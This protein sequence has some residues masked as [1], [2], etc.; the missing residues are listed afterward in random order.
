MNATAC[1]QTLA[2]TAASCVYENCPA[3]Y[4]LSPVES[5]MYTGTFVFC[6]GQCSYTQM[7]VVSSIPV[8]P[9][10]ARV[11]VHGVPFTTTVWGN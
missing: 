9:V 10:L 6:A 11:V 1:V 8:R 5:V 3:W 2:P 7:T 4:L